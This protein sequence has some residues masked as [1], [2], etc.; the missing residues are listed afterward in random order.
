M[1]SIQDIVEYY[2]ELFPVTEDIQNFYSQLTGSYRSPVRILGIASN[3]GTL[4][5][6]LARNNCD[7]TGIEVSQPLLESSI[8]KRRTQLMSIRF[9]QLSTIEMNK[10]L[11]KDFYHI[12]YCLNNRIT[13]IRN[14]EYME[15]FFFDCRELLKDGGTVVLHVH[16]YEKLSHTEKIML[17]PR[18]SIRATLSTDIHVRND[19]KVAVTQILETGNGKTRPIMVDEEVYPLV[20]KDIIRFGKKAGFRDFSFYSGFSLAPFTDD[21]ENLLCIIK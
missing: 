19:R 2:D 15:K 18:K 12:I 6:S 21:S 7:V 8:L 4:E 10:F 16:N 13:Y 17:S 5:I 1:E 20:R 14:Q 11:G 3:T 9:F